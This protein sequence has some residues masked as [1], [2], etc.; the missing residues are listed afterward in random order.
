MNRATEY[1]SICELGEVE[2]RMYVVCEPF[3]ISQSRENRS[4]VVEVFTGEPRNSDLTRSPCAVRELS[5]K[6]TS[7]Q[8]ELTSGKIG[9]LD[10]KPI[11]PNVRR[12]AKCLTRV[13]SSPVSFRKLFWALE[14]KLVSGERIIE[15]L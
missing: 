1:P 7:A 4:G 12:V 2:N 11:T 3:S 13:C 6:T 5:P 9:E 14:I 15:A 10:P 8:T